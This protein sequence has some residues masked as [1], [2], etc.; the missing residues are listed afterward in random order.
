[1]D[2][3]HSHLYSGYYTI[4]D[5]KLNGDKYTIWLGS[6]KLILHG[7]GFI[8]RIDGTPP[9]KKDSASSDVPPDSPASSA[10]Q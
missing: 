5:M 6:V 7:L 3:H 1:M 8:R 4:V 2:C 9:P 10:S